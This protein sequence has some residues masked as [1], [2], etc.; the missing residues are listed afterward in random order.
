MNYYRN[1]YTDRITNTQVYKVDDKIGIKYNI[2]YRINDKNGKA[3]WV[4]LPFSD[5]KIL[6]I[7]YGSTNPELFDK[8]NQILSTFQFIE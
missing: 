4:Y 8:F 2:S 3:I 7:K 5:E 1:S 6:Y